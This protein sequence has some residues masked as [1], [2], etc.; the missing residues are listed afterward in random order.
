M[1]DPDK[2]P[3]STV[4]SSLTDEEVDQ[5]RCKTLGK[6]FNNAAT[7]L[8][9]V[10]YYNPLLLLM[11]HLYHS[12]PKGRNECQHPPPTSSF[13]QSFLPSLPL[14]KQHLSAALLIINSGTK[15]ESGKLQCFFEH[16]DGR[17]AMDKNRI[18]LDAGLEKWLKDVQKASAS[19]P[20]EGDTQ[21]EHQTVEEG[22]RRA[23][24]RVKH[25]PPA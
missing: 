24:K 4:F 12:R 23:S 9:D 10:K 17:N 2:Y 14:S 6:D 13:A 18:E 5:Y 7:A 1:E 8:W 15:T 25:N 16:E 20:E 11:L 21:R 19:E 22:H 3:L